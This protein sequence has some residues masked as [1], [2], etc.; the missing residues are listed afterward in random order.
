MRHKGKNNTFPEEEEEKEEEDTTQVVVMSSDTN[1]EREREENASRGAARTNPS[2][3]A[4]MAPRHVC[5]ISRSGP[6]RPPSW[7]RWNPPPA[8]QSLPRLLQ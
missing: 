4:L 7:V 6:R 5:S 2:F 3:P 1:K 8:H